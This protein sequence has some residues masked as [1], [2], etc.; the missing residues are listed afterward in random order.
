MPSYTHSYQIDLTNSPLPTYDITLARISL[1]ETD[2]VKFKLNLTA[3]VPHATILSEKRTV[4]I[5]ASQDINWVD[6]EIYIPKVS[7]NRGYAGIGEVAE[8]LSQA[9]IGTN[10]IVGLI[11]VVNLNDD[12]KPIYFR[13][14]VGDLSILQLPLNY[15]FTYTGVKTLKTESANDPVLIL[16]IYA[17]QDWFTNVQFNSN[18]TLADTAYRPSK[19]PI[20]VAALHRKGFWVTGDSISSA[21]TNTSNPLLDQP[22]AILNGVMSTIWKLDPELREDNNYQVY[23]R[24]LHAYKLAYG[25]VP[26]PLVLSILTNPQQYMGLAEFLITAPEPHLRKFIENNVRTSMEHYGTTAKTLTEEAGNK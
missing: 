17:G 16:R 9:V 25:F 20:F 26:A 22:S 24:A 5:G 15:S 1:V 14:E 19:S 6:A 3:L 7:M 12:V 10:A 2:Y 4:L 11:E 21:A 18:L 23:H 8:Q 13:R